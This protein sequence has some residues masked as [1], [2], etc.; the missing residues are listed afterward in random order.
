MCIHNYRYSVV[1]PL[2]LKRFPDI[3]YVLLY[4][5]MT[6]RLNS[7]NREFAFAGLAAA[8]VVIVT[9]TGAIDVVI[10]D[11]VGVVAVVVDGVSFES[12]M[13][14]SASLPPCYNMCSR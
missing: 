10:L 2:L 5:Q 12:L 13:L 8:V 14:V 1:V 9:C 11:R 3:R 6:W 4:F 7:L